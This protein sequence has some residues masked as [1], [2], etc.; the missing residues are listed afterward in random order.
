M[1]SEV[2]FYL[3]V[4]FHWVIIYSFVKVVLF[5]QIDQVQQNPEDFILNFG[6]LTN[7]FS[8]YLK[9]LYQL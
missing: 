6:S 8:K 2:Q 9:Y 5:I 1:I 4:V 7:I 3:N